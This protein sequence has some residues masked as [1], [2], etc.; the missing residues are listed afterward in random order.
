MT[1]SIF[2]FHVGSSSSIFNL[3]RLIHTG[4]LELDNGSVVTLGEDSSEELIACL[5]AAMEVLLSNS[6]SDSEGGLLRSA[7]SGRT[8]LES[9]TLF[10][11]ASGEIRGPNDRVRLQVR[12]AH[13][14]W[15]SQSCFD[16]TYELIAKKR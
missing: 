16:M 10:I 8:C 3:T 6:F 9:V 11:S 5:R 2:T 7:T 15:V 12:L 14:M 13:P 1:S 4:V